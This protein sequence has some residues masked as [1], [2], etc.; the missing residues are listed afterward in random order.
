MPT[1]YHSIGLK[2]MLL[3]WAGKTCSPNTITQYKKYTNYP[4]VIIS[5]PV[6][7]FKSIHIQILVWG[8]N[9]LSHILCGFPQTFHE[10][11]WVLPSSRPRPLPHYFKSINCNRLTTWL[12]IIYAAENASLNK[13]S[14]DEELNKMQSFTLYHMLQIHNSFILL[15]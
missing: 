7:Y 11:A 13:P 1:E 14:S 9:F 12:H 6:L 4:S 10:N 15:P 5:T 2:Q 8:Q 3:H